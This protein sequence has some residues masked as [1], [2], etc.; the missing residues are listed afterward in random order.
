LGFRFVNGHEVD[1]P[2]F[3]RV[4][5]SGWIFDFL[6]ASAFDYQ[7]LPFQSLSRVKG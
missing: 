3:G 6:A 5:L 1:P 7:I 4:E 2:V